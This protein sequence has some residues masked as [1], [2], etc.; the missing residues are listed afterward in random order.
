MDGRRVNKNK[1]IEGRKNMFEN[2][3][4]KELLEVD[5][6]FVITASMIATGAGILASGVA[7]GYAVGKIF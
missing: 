6:G 3:S 7:V 5:G 2:M 4:D 1:D